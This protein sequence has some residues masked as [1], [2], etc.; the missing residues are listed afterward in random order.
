MLETVCVYVYICI[1]IRCCAIK[2]QKKQSLPFLDLSQ[3]DLYPCLKLQ[4]WQC[5]DTKWKTPAGLA[6]ASVAG[7]SGWFQ[8]PVLVKG[9]EKSRWRSLFSDVLR[10]TT[11]SAGRVSLFFSRNPEAS[12]DTCKMKTKLQVRQ[13]PWSLVTPGAVW[14]Q[15]F[16]DLCTELILAQPCF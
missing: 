5:W 8:V 6:E 13:C 9:I 14:V 15:S 1:Y 16:I 12:Y 11:T 2:L 10:T 4:P 3:I 7:L